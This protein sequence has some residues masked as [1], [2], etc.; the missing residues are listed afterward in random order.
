MVYKPTNTGWWFGPWMDYD[1]PFSWECHHPNWRTPSFFR[2]V[3]IPP[4]RNWRFISLIQLI[5]VYTYTPIHIGEEW[6]LGEEHGKRTRRPMLEPWRSDM[7][8]ACEIG[9]EWLPQGTW[10]PGIF[11]VCS[12]KQVISLSWFTEIGIKCILLDM[13]RIGSFQAK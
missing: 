5:C 6:G 12:G 8:K 2:G 11:W 13:I 9:M 1:F 3:G 10:H 7:V 4:T